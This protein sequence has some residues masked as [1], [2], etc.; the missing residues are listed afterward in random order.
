MKTLSFYKSG[1]ME[2]LQT[3]KKIINLTLLLLVVIFSETLAW[4][5]ESG[6]EWDALSPGEKQILASLQD[7]WNTLSPETQNRLNAGARKWNALS[8]KQ[9]KPSNKNSRHENKYQKTRKI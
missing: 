5:Q 4:C 8:V 3:R 2:V 7:K 1:R 9:K 6:I